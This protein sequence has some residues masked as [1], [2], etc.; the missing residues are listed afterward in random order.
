MAAKTK[1]S[2]LPD[3]VRERLGEQRVAALA[4]QPMALAAGGMDAIVQQACTECAGYPDPATAAATR[5]LQLCGSSGRTLD[6]PTTP[7]ES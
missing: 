5:T 6:A 7:P 2:T 1:P 4:L 3:Q